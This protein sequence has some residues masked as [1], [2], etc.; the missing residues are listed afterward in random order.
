MRDRGARQHMLFAMFDAVNPG[1]QVVIVHKGHVTSE[2][3]V[4]GDF[5]E[6]IPPAI[7]SF[8]I[9]AQT[10]EQVVMLSSLRSCQ[11][12]AKIQETREG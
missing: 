7:N 5:G 10:V 9:S 4:R 3:M 2:I 6:C 12:A 8:F 1:L 11:T